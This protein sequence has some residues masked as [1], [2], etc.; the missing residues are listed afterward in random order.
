[1]K[2]F[3]ALGKVFLLS[4]SDKKKCQDTKRAQKTAYANTGKKMRI[5]R[6]QKR[7]INGKKTYQT[8]YKKEMKTVN[9]NARS[10]EK[11]IDYL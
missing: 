3:N 2:L 5:A 7:H 8:E 4:L 6:K 9:Q 11:F 10:R 1:M